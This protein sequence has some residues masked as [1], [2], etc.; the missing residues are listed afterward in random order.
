MGA[1]KLHKH[2]AVG[3]LGIHREVLAVP[4]LAAAEVSLSPARLL[5]E[6]HRPLISGIRYAY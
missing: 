5:I 4:V 3:V 1:F 2:L 6:E